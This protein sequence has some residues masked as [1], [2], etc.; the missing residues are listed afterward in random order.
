MVYVNVTHYFIP[1][2]THA[3]LASISDTESV[4]DIC[5][6]DDVPPLPPPLPIVIKLLKDITQTTG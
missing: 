5:D 1:S 3:E 6:N 4:E 2:L